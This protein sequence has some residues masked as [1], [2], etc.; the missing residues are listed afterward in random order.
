MDTFAP[1]ADE[2]VADVQFTDDELHVK[3]MDGRTISVPLAWYPRLL[4]ATKEQRKKWRISAGGYGIHR[5][6]VDEDIS[7][8]GLLRGAAAPRAR[9]LKHL[10]DLRISTIDVFDQRIEELKGLLYRLLTAESF[11]FDESLRSN[12]PEEPGVYVIYSVANGQE[13]VL[14]A[15]RAAGVGGLR[16]RIYQNHLMGKQS[17]NLRAQLVR[18]GRCSD[19][20]GA[21]AWIRQ[22]CSVRF[23]VVHDDET[24]RWTEHFMLAVLRP[25]YSD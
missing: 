4:K 17:G 15:G 13:E 7:V 5:P 22:S 19:M 20:E 8:E 12:L 24:L 1:N 23:L 18:S 16:Q 2:R 25:T 9:V 6:D 3:L 21:K 14:R 10:P 11:H